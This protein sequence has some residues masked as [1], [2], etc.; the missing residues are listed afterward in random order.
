MIEN[1]TPHLDKLASDQLAEEQW[2]KPLEFHDPSLAKFP[3]DAFPKTLGEFISALATETQTPVDLCGSLVLAVLATACARKFRVRI[4][5]SW[6]EPTNLY[7]MVVMGP[8]NRKSGVFS[9]VTKPIFEFEREEKKRLLPEHEKQK[10]EREQD[11]LRLAKLK[12]D[13][14]NNSNPNSSGNS[15]PHPYNADPI[16]ELTQLSLKIGQTQL[17]PL[18]QYTVDDCTPERLSTLLTQHGRMAVLSA[19]GGVFDIIAGRYSGSV[20]NLD[21]YLKGHSGDYLQVDREKFGDNSQSVSRPALTFGLA[22]QPDVLNG[23]VSKPGFRGRGLLGRFLY[24]IPQELLGSRNPFAPSV[25][26]TVSKEYDSTVFKILSLPWNQ[27]QNK[28]ITHY[29]LLLSEKASALF[30]LYELSI[31]EKFK[32]FREL[33]AIRDWGGKLV[34]AVA[35]IAGLLHIAKHFENPKPWELKIEEETVEQA[36][37]LGEYFE[38]HASAAFFQMGAD[39]RLG[40]AKFLLDWIRKTRVDE[41]PRSQAWQSLKGT[42]GKM[43]FLKES[44]NL[45][46]EHNYLRKIDPEKTG[47]P[48]RPKG[49]AYEVNPYLLAENYQNP[50]NSVFQ[51]QEDNFR[52][53]GDISP[54][55]SPNV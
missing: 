17:T 18:P 54:G 7:I 41:F 34:G 25:P 5:G 19:E 51:P 55:E 44:L 24:S 31:E 52:N 46:V 39:E 9:L 23:L 4:R 15:D 1:K 10:N 12:K 35:R 21:V 32:I 26:E 29:N 48:G 50:Q 42:F 14:A 30:T 38:S 27:D 11:E 6:E 43:A 13:L 53:I 49:E 3:V 45:L 22:V 36:R 2:T 28:E 33:Y 20:P 37:R 47:R 8:G 16:E 40:K